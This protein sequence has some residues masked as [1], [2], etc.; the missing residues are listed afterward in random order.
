MRSDVM[1]QE[2][3]RVELKRVIAAIK[4]FG[5]NRNTGF[6]YIYVDNKQFVIEFGS[7]RGRFPVSGN[8]TGYLQMKVQ[9][10]LRAE[11]DVSTDSTAVFTFEGETL[12]IDGMAVARCVWKA[13]KP[14]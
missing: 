4:K 6:A 5:K 12:A 1:R 7:V 14:T 2:V 9:L 11:T 10:L 3:P 8:W 13:S